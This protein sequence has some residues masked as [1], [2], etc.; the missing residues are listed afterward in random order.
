MNLNG[1]NINGEEKSYKVGISKNVYCS[2]DNLIELTIPKTLK[3]LYCHHN[4]LTHLDLPKTLTSLSCYN[5]NLIHLD[6]PDKLTYLNCVNNN[7]TEIVL[8]KTIRLAYL[9]LNCVILNIDEFRNKK[10]V[11]IYFED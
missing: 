10:D 1:I 11:F 7:I 3:E 8:H 9:P 2:Y 6:L 5:N 4:S